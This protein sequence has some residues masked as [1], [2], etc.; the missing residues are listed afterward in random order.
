MSANMTNDH[1]VYLPNTMSYSNADVKRPTSTSRSSGLEAALLKAV[2]FVAS[3]PSR[4]AVKNELSRLSDRELS[5]IGLSRSE[6]AT[7]FS[8][9]R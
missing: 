7:V 9:N 8:R 1:V 4:Q 6:I 3:I 2:R 5:D